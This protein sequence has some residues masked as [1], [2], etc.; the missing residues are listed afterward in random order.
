MHGL[1]GVIAGGHRHAAGRPR[2]AYAPGST[3]TAPPPSP[4]ASPRCRTCCVGRLRHHRPRR[5]QGPGRLQFLL[6]CAAVLL[7]SVVLVRAAPGRR[8]LRRRRLPRRRGCP[9]HLRRHRSPRPCRAETAAVPPWP[10]SASSASCPAGPPASPGC[11]SATRSPD[12][13]AFARLAPSDRRRRSRWTTERIAAQARRGHETAPRPRRRLR[14]R[15]RR[16]RRRCSAS[17][18]RAGPSCSPWPPGWPC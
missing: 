11:P 1:P 17:P 18:Q 6:G 7:A 8:A 13:I 14:D 2:R 15:R 3:P 9:R 4:S 10:R 5:G 12:Q 16:R